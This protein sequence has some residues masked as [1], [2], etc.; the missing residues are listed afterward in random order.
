MMDKK[1]VI[2]SIFIV[3]IIHVSIVNAIEDNGTDIT[4]LSNNS[5]DNYLHS[6]NDEKSINLNYGDEIQVN[7]DSSVEG[8]VTVL[9]DNE[10]YIF[11]NF[12]E[13]K[14]IIIPTYKLSSF[15]DNNIKNIDIGNHKLSLIFNLNSYNHFIPSISQHDSHLKFKFNKIDDNIINHKYTYIF[16]STLNIPKKEKSIHITSLSKPPYDYIDYY[17]AGI[18]F[19]IQF[20]NIHIDDIY[21]DDKSSGYSFGLLLIKNSN[22]IYK[23]EVDLIK[24]FM[25]VE[26]I[27]LL[28]GVICDFWY[29]LPGLNHDTLCEIGVCNLTVINFLDGSSD[30]ILLDI[31][32]FYT[33]Y[34]KIDCLIYGSDVT[35]YFNQFFP[36]FFINVDGQS[37]YFIPNETQRSV[38]FSNLA[39]GFHEMKLY[40]LNRDYSK[41]ILTTLRF[42]IKYFNQD[43]INNTVTLPLNNISFN[44]FPN[45]ILNNPKGLLNNLNYGISNNIMHKLKLDINRNNINNNFKIKDNIPSAGESN[46]DGNNI[47]SNSHKSSSDVQS[48]E[49]SKKSSTKS[50]NNLLTKLGLSIVSCMFFMIGYYRFEKTK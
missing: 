20:N 24:S 12:S 6:L 10:E 21:W 46:N 1:L 47:G 31:S 30:S 19:A 37:K 39:P 34:E 16:N 27:I 49:I 11:E 43:N 45:L 9:I 4:T 23:K 44:L 28:D 7:V 25:Q 29:D 36:E 8:N 18:G 35:F 38:T 41:Q 22:I 2:L 13:S 40:Y 26:D 33:Y 42:E 50:I 14:T 5:E 17:F 48:Y 15:Y 3:L 32:K